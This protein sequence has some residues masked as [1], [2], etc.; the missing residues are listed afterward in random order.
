MHPRVRTVITG[1]EEAN[2]TISTL[3]ASSPLYMMQLNSHMNE[4]KDR[5]PNLQLNFAVYL[6]ICSHVYQAVPCNCMATKPTKTVHRQAET[7]LHNEGM[8]FFLWLPGIELLA[9][10]IIATC[11]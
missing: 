2:C 3:H 11:I 5:Q 1:N 7:Y 8:C 4:T 6:R 10:V 9:D